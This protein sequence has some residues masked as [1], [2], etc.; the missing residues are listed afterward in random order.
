MIVV[1]T[2]SLERDPGLFTELEAGLTAVAMNSRTLA[3]GQGGKKSEGKSGPNCQLEGRQ[4]HSFLS[5]EQL[6]TPGFSGLFFSQHTLG[7]IAD[8]IHIA[9]H[10][11]AR[12]LI[13]L[14][15]YESTHCPSQ[16]YGTL[17][18]VAS[19]QANGIG[20]QICWPAHRYLSPVKSA[21]SR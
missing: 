20:L 8:E 5:P 9:S 17:Q 18:L 21:R 16:P 2:N 1:P 19:R 10:G 14:D 7:L 4:F 6:A 3:E 15:G 13:R 12:H 11:F